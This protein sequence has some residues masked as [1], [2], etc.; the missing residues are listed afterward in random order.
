MGTTAVATSVATRGEVHGA[1]TTARRS[2]R[3]NATIRGAASPPRVSTMGTTAVA[4]SVATHG[5]VH[6]AFT[7]ATMGTTAVATSVAT[8]GEV[9]GAFTTARAVPSKAHGTKTTIQAVPSKFTWT[10]AQASHSHAPRI[11]QPASIIQPA[12]IKQPTLTTQPA[13]AEQPA[14]VTQPAP[15][16]QP[17]PVAQPAF[18]EQ[19]TPVAQPA[20]AKQPTPVA[21]PALAK[22]PALVTQPRR[23]THSRGPACFFR[24]AHSHGPACSRGFPSSP[25]RPKTIPTIRTYHRAGGILTIFFRGFDISQ[26]K[27]RS[28][29]LPP[30][31]CPRRRIPSKLFQSKWRTTLV[32][33]SRRVDERPCTIDNLGE[34]TFA[35]HW[36][37]TCPGRGIPK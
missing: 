2:L 31:H 18:V 12:P 32:S 10:Q 3:Q 21:Q 15:D 33:T 19:P 26:L 8:R 14:L 1:F 5:E 22:Q 7:T 6:G 9:H 4:T 34:S 17:T 37:P 35:T 24:A 28:R 36:D 11:E 27:S 29:S 13:P 30:F 25:S 23:A 16:E 20:P